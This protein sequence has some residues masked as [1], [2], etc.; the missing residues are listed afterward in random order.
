MVLTFVTRSLAGGYDHDG[1][2]DQANKAQKTTILREGNI[3]DKGADRISNSS[4]VCDPIVQ[5]GLRLRPGGRQADR[6]SSSAHGH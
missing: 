5:H 4:G 6:L 1:A 2:G 3:Y